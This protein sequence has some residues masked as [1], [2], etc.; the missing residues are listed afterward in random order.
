MKFATTSTI[1]GPE[2]NVIGTG[3]GVDVDEGVAVGISVK[4]P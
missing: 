4:V 2:P 1:S 3:V